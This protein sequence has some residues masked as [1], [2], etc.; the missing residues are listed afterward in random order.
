MLLCVP[1]GKKPY[2]SQWVAALESL[3]QRFMRGSSVRGA[4]GTQTGCSPS[5][6]IGVGWYVQ[7]EGRG[8]RPHT[9]APPL[10]QKLFVC[11]KLACVLMCVSL[12][13]L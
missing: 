2:Q 12:G 5:F 1:W 8:I 11:E 13:L 7:R 4:I 9:W 6:T 10:G 3:E